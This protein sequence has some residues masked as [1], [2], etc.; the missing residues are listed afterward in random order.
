MVTGRFPYGYHLRQNVM[1]PD[2]HEMA[3]DL[4]RAANNVKQRGELQGS[5]CLNINS[6]KNRNTRK[7]AWQRVSL[8]G[9][10]PKSCETKV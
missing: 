3:K 2:Q 6:S 1:N 10:W 4:A 8:D 7:L 5:P 9:K